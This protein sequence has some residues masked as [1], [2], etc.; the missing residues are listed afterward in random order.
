MPEAVLT[1]RLNPKTGE[2]TL[3]IHYESDPDAMSYEHEDDHR[4]FVEQLLGRPLTEVADKLEVQREPPH[5]LIE[6]RRHESIQRKQAS[7]ATDEEDSESLDKSLG[8]SS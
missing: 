7:M 2:R 8:E 5:P 6:E 1:L 3:S 4:A